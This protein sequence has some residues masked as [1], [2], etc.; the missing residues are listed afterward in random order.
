M[1][2]A[3]ATNSESPCGDQPKVFTNVSMN[4][5]D[6]NSRV[7]LPRPTQESVV[8]VN[9]GPEVWCGPDLRVGDRNFSILESSRAWAVIMLAWPSKGFLEKEKQFWNTTVALP[10]TKV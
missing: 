10:N 8:F 7:L 6:H 5:H 1:R 2:I 4:F 3:T 9:N